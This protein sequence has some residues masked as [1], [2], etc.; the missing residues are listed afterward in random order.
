MRKILES[1]D[2]AIDDQSGRH[3]SHNQLWGTFGDAV[4]GEHVG[5]SGQRAAH[6]LE[7][8]CFS[9]YR[10][11]RV[12][13]VFLWLVEHV[14]ADRPGENGGSVVIDARLQMPVSF[15][16]GCK[17]VI[18]ESRTGM[19]INL[20]SGGEGRCGITRRHLCGKRS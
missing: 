16:R 12:S 8:V 2:T 20:I 18:R 14:G 11:A 6:L 19:L 5:S 17:L 9:R 10:V 4:R 13:E 7:Q 3:D 1:R 15:W